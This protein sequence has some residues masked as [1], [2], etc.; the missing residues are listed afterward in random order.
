[1]LLRRR[2]SHLVISNTSASRVSRGVPPPE[3]PFPQTA[4]DQP[5]LDVALNV[6]LRAAVQGTGATAAAMALMRDGQLVCRAR[7]GDIAPDLGV[8]LNANTGITGACV[9]SAKILHCQDTETDLRVDSKI[10]R[11]LGIRSILVVPIVLNGEVT[12]ILEVFAPNDRAFSSE[13]IKWLTIVAHFVHANIH[14][15]ASGSSQGV[16]PDG[17]APPSPVVVRHNIL[18]PASPPGGLQAAQQGSRV[19]V[20]EDPGLPELVE[21]LKDNLPQAT[22]D[23]ICEQLASR[24]K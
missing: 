20:V 2:R 14:A 1:M 6:A 11:E 12:G 3:T 18:E 23:V 7:V 4:F 5:T 21:A 10:C 22:W 15:T 16:A 9:R 8:V 24:F 13:H 17:K 19:L